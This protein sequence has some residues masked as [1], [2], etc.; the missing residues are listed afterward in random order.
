M[1]QDVKATTDDYSDEGCPCLAAE[2]DDASPMKGR[3]LVV[4]V[5]LYLVFLFS[6]YRWLSN[7]EAQR[8]QS[9]NPSSSLPPRFTG[10]ELGQGVIQDGTTSQECAI[11]LETMP[12]GTT[13]RILPCRHSFHHDC[14]VGWL[15]QDKDSCPLCKFDLRQHFE[16][17]RAAVEIIQTAHNSWRD[18]LLQGRR[19]WRWR[20]IRTDE[21]QLLEEAGEEGGDLELTEESS[22]LVASSEES[23]E[24][25]MIV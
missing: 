7:G 3:D 25:G 24:E 19:V 2:I 5:C 20:R 18:R 13:V 21:N 23:S 4:R 16:E 1:V 17:Q 9:S 8:P 15:D 14:I 12:A 22:T 11:C 10:S 6:V